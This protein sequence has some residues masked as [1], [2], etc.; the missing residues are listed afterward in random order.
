MHELSIA[1]SIMGIVL[2]SVPSNEEKHVKIVRVKVGELTAVVPESLE[3]CFEAITAG[4][5]LEGAKLEIEHIGITGKCKEC[6]GVFK[7]A[8]LTFYCQYCN[9]PNI[10]IISGNEL[11]VSEIETED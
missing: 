7:V 8:S 3:F 11:Q 10:E 9:S 1:S 2:E 5:P 6:G 4:T